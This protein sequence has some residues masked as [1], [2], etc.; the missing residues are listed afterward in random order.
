M[1][2]FQHRG[3]HYLILA[4]AAGLLFFWNLGTATLWDL[5]EG[6]NAT[7]SGEMN[8]YPRPTTGSRRRSTTRS[9]STSRCCSIGCK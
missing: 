8:A 9:A 6:R 1:A 7:C 2:F 5:D 4:A 3:G